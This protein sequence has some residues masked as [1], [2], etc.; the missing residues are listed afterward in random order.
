MTSSI[1]VG[2]VAVVVTLLIAIPVTWKV[3]VANKTKKDAEKIGT[4]EEKA[5]SIIDDAIKAAETK[6]REALLEIKEE[7][8]RTKNEVDKEIK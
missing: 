1:I 2:I 6:K 5:R 8:L 3:A 4:A 7:S